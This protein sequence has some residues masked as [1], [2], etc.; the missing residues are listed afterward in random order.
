MKRR[1]LKTFVV[2]QKLH[3]MQLYSA[4]YIF[5]EQ[6]V[7]K[8]L[9]MFQD[10]SFCTYRVTRGTKTTGSVF[11]YKTVRHCQHFRKYVSRQGIK[12]TKSIRQ[13]KTQCPSTH[14]IKVYSSRSTIKKRLNQHMHLVSEMYLKVLRRLITATFKMGL[15]LQQDI[16]MN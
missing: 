1:N 13:K 2:H 6:E 3:L 4:I 14:T 11:I 15:Q 9:R 5:S 10:K 8:W 16:T 7:M 12:N